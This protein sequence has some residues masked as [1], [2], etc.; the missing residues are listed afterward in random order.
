MICEKCQ[1]EATVHLSESSEGQEREVHL[2]SVCARKAGIKLPKL[3]PDLALDAVIQGL[4]TANVGEIVGALALTRCT[5]CETTFKDYRTDLRLGCPVDYRV[6]E[7][8]LLPMLKQFHQ[9]TRHVGKIPA[10]ILV[11]S[12]PLLRMRAQLRE[13]VKVEDFERAAALRDEIRIR[14]RT[15]PE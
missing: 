8:A 9:S 4:I 14:Q 1:D 7:T 12:E 13:A 2:C 3:A 10:R 11:D 15:N 6:F 5:C